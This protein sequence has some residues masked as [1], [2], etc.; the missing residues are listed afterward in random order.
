AQTG[1]APGATQ[2]GGAS[3]A[4]QTTTAPSAGHPSASSQAPA[5]SQEAVGH[6]HVR[7]GFLPH[8]T[9]EVNPEQVRA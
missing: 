6:L 4:T 3:G 8:L 2:T 9:P 1:G 7:S 5:P